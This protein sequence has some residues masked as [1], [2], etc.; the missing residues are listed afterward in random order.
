MKR[1]NIVLIV[2]LA[3][4]VAA[5]I[6][7]FVMFR[8]FGGALY[9]PRPHSE[10]GTGSQRN[11]KPYGQ[12]RFGATRPDGSREF[13]LEAEEGIVLA[14]F[15]RG[16]GRTTLVVH[17]GPGFASD[18]PFQGLAA[19]EGERKFVYWHQRGSG[20]ST[21][22]IDR[23]PTKNYPENVKELDAKL[24]LSAQIGDIERL[25][26][27]LGEEKI[28]IIGHSF[29]GLL[30]CLYAIEYPG[31]AEK[32]LLAAP[33]HLIVMPS[34]D[35][36]LYSEIERLLPEADK[37]AYSAWL[38]DFF[39]YGKL[40][41]RSEEELRILNAGIFPF[42]AKA[43]AL[44]GTGPEEIEKTEAALVGGWMMQAIFFSMGKA[45]DWSKVFSGIGADVLLVYGDRDVSGPEAF[46]QYRVVPGIRFAEAKGCD[47]FLLEEPEKLAEAMGGFFD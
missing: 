21:R 24:G 3:I 23:F 5:G 22:P 20:R 6:G 45:H 17:G 1:R 42:Y 28:D 35:G 29:G 13:S 47:H 26:L 32:I 14:G 44:K 15:V 11:S 8:G 16:K 34:K 2:I 18:T 46:A 43:A 19:F 33:A 30:A 12:I 40:F 38:K 27:A 10:G 31:R 41:S 7:I 4:L 39:D 25:R 36:G 37:K 9:E